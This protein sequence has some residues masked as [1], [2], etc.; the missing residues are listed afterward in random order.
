MAITGKDA[1]CYF[2][3]MTPLFLG[4]KGSYINMMQEDRWNQD[5]LL[6][7]IDQF[8]VCVCARVTVI[9]LQI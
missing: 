4:I 3:G 9:R 6:F 7:F 8:W 5:V 1:K 2:N